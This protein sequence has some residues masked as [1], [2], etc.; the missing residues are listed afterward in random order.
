MKF[1]EDFRD[2]HKKD[3]EIWILGCGSSLDDFPDDFFDETKNRMSIALNWSIIGFPQCTYW[4]VG[5]P[6]APVWMIKRKPE[7]LK[8]S[9]FILPFA[10]IR[11]GAWLTEEE[12]LELLDPYRNDPIY[13]RWHFIMGNLKRFQI[14][15]EPTVQCIMKRRTCRYICLST[16]VHY[17]IQ[18]A[19][20]LGGKKIN[21]VGCEAALRNGRFHAVKRGMSKFYTEKERG[22]GNEERLKIYKLGVSLL[23]K[24]FRPYG[25]EIRRYYYGKGYRSVV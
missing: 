23:A 16:S 1:I 2:T 9:I 19:I 24:A 18:T 10:P 12:S 14:L 21:L 20:V 13:M 7:I 5:H 15:L 4:H 11:R 25:I 22:R 6:N 3:K 17:A 8:K